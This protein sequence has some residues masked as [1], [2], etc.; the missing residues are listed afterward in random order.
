MVLDN[1]SQK[2]S[3]DIFNQYAD[4]EKGFYRT[5]LPIIHM[6]EDGFPVSRS[7]ARRIY[8]LVERF[9]EV[10]LDFQCVKEIGQAFVHELFVV[11]AKKNPEIK[12]IWKMRVKALPV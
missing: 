9:E 4:A 1:Q 11:F 3:S 7:Q 10:I 5:R 6:V 12:L 2:I 8:H